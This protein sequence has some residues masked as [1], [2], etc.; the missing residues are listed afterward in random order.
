MVSYIC[1]KT[2]SS[3]NVGRLFKQKLAGKIF[4]SGAFWARSWGHNCIHICVLFVLL[5]R[6]RANSHLKVF[7]LLLKHEELDELEQFGAC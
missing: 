1:K 4:V 2:A 5:D 6:T 7:V 3:L